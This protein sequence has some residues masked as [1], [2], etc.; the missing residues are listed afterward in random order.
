MSIF[1]EEIY[2]IRYLSEVFVQ[3]ERTQHTRRC[4]EFFCVV[5]P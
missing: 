2:G 4:S 5:L 3:K 1:L